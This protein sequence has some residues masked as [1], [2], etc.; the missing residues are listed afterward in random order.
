M[1]FQ[2][3]KHQAQVE[4]LVNSNKH[5]WNIVL[6]LFSLFQKTEAEGIFYSSF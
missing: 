5:L 2:N 3:R 6:I 1:T 4:L